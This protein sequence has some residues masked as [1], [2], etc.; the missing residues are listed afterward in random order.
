M[1]DQLFFTTIY[2]HQ[3]LLLVSGTNDGAKFPEM[4]DFHEFVSN[5][6][7]ALF[8]SGKL[9]HDLDLPI[10][11]L[12]GNMKPHK[13]QKIHEFELTLDDQRVYIGDIKKEAFLVV[14]TGI[15][16]FKVSFYID[17]KEDMTLLYLYIPTP[18]KLIEQG[19][20]FEQSREV[21]QKIQA[22]GKESGCHIC[23]NKKAEKYIPHLLPPI[24]IDPKSERSWYPICEPDYAKYRHEIEEILKGLI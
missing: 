2:L 20:T 15:D 12:V 11:V 18:L 7:A 16:K 6:K 17:S 22:I 14:G 21:Q 23:G 3:T 24:E 13:T 8:S 5:K 4:D 1:K 9:A 19:S 10:R